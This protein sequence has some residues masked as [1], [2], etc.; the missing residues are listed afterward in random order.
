MKWELLL[1]T[2]EKLGIAKELSHI[3]LQMLLRNG[4]SPQNFSADNL[5]FI[6]QA[7]VNVG[8]SFVSG[9]DYKKAIAHFALFKSPNCEQAMDWTYE[10]IEVSSLFTSISKGEEYQDLR[11]FLYMHYVGGNVTINIQLGSF[12]NGL[13]FIELQKQHANTPEIKGFLIENEVILLEHMKAYGP[14]IELIKKLEPQD[15][16]QKLFFQYHLALNCFLSNRLEQARAYCNKLVTYLCKIIGAPNYSYTKDLLLHTA[17]LCKELKLLPGAH[18]LSLKGYTYG[19][20][21][22]EEKYTIWFGLELIQSPLSSSSEKGEWVKLLEE[23]VLICEYTF[24]DCVENRL[25]KMKGSKV[26]SQYFKNL[27]KYVRGNFT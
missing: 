13:Q 16:L 9:K 12:A 5:L 3:L 10:G 22:L 1:S 15:A 11:N 21:L 19:K 26:S 27:V 6:F 23:D 24:P 17:R 18:L 14:A 4:T 2:K 20:Q 8:R 7:L 25:G